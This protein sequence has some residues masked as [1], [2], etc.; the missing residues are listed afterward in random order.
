[1]IKTGLINIVKDAIKMNASDIHFTQIESDNV[2]IQLRAGN[3]MLP[4]SHIDR[5][6]SK[7]I[8]AYHI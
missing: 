3:I 6:E 8:L 7:K 1:M 5:K 2:L 4:R